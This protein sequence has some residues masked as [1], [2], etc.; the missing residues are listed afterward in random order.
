MTKK[1]TRRHYKKGR[2][3][4]TE[5]EKLESSLRR[6]EWEAAWRIE[7]YQYRPEK[8]LLWAAKKRAKERGLDYDLE[9]SDIK[10]PTHCPYLGILLVNSR[11]RGDSRKDI[12]SLDRIDNTKGYTKDNIEVISWLANTMKSNATV[13]Q[14]Q[15]FAT[16]ILKRYPV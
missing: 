5:E 1:L 3:P 11:P 15:K 9:E 10:V 12:A 14:L 2:P 6:K 4:Q 7:Y 8:R 16:E 13:E